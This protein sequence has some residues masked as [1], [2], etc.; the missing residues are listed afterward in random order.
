MSLRSIALDSPAQ[1]SGIIGDGATFGNLTGNI[2]TVDSIVVGTLSAGTITTGT[3]TQPTNSLYGTIPVSSAGNFSRVNL[4][5]PFYYNITNP[6]DP[7]NPT[8]LATMAYSL[9]SGTSAPAAITATFSGGFLNVYPG[10][11]NTITTLGNNTYVDILWINNPGST[12]PG[13]APSSLPPA[14]PRISWFISGSPPATAPSRWGGVVDFD[15]PGVWFPNT[16]TPVGG[17]P[18][19]VGLTTTAVIGLPGR[20]Y[21]QFST[22][23]NGA[24]G[25][26]DINEWTSSSGSLS[27]PLVADTTKWWMP[28]CIT[29]CRSTS[30]TANPSQ[31]APLLYTPPN[32]LGTP[33]TWVLST[34]QTSP[35]VAPT[36]LFPGFWVQDVII[37]STQSRRITSITGAMMALNQQPYS[38]GVGIR[39]QVYGREQT[40]TG[41]GFW[42]DWQIGTSF[43]D[44]NNIGQYI[45]FTTG[46]Y[47][48]GIVLGCCGTNGTANTIAWS[49]NTTTTG[50]ANSLYS[51]AQGSRPNTDI[52]TFNL[53]KPPPP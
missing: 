33:N 52:R 30:T 31:T 12:A 47:Q 17:I 39:F 50:V 8:I 15:T 34:Q 10:C 21:Y 37:R 42:I 22:F 43:P 25:A 46:V 16:A 13:V 51:L 44:P 36:G 5:T 23:V 26:Y 28:Y 14:S 2:L 3:D 35:P 7:L 49:S 18:S 29:P 6:N 19:F 38:T 41:G 27:A 24:G 32:S 53:P 45:D 11:S 40:N 4:Q 48:V 20:A 9:V 1:Q